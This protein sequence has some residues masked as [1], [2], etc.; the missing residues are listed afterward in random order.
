MYAMYPVTRRGF[1]RMPYGFPVRLPRTIVLKGYY[2]MWELAVFCRAS[3]KL[4]CI[5]FLSDSRNGGWFPC[6]FRKQILGSWHS[7][8]LKIFVFCI[9]G[10]IV[11]GIIGKSGEHCF[12]IVE[13]YFSLLRFNLSSGT[14][15]GA[16]VKPF[17]ERCICA[18]GM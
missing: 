2:R 10:L 3:A 16:P 17:P 8:R 12:Q 1:C 5:F 15:R 18:F 14:T 4:W 13:G 6:R 9:F 11:I 7:P